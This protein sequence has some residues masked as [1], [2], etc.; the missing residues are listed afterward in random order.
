M[1]VRAGVGFNCLLPLHPRRARAHHTCRRRANPARTIL[2]TLSLLH[3]IQNGPQE[4]AVN[5]MPSIIMYLQSS[6]YLFFGLFPVMIWIIWLGV[7]TCERDD[8]CSQ[9]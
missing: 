2:H 3:N 9:K 1:Y 5:R 8:A 7:Q 6:A 4:G